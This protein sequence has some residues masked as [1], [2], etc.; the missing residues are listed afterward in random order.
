LHAGFNDRLGRLVDQARQTRQRAFLRQQRLDLATQ[1][2]IALA[3]LVKKRASHARL[4]FE[5]PMVELLDLL[6][7]FRA[8]VQMSL[9]YGS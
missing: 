3:C 4:S 6:E 5:G 2:D 9:L 7:A 1:L 8:Y